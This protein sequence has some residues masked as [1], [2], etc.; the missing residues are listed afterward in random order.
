MTLSARQNEVLLWVARG[1]TSQETGQI[2]GLSKR[3]VDRYL[4]T[5]Y[6]KLGAVN[7]VEA[8]FRAGIITW[9]KD[10]DPS[11][12]LSTPTPR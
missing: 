11:Q 10:Y 4:A 3:T 9:T 6:L 5:A 2:L 1:K 12:G 7:R 8:L